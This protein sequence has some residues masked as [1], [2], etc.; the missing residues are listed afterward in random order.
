MAV[1]T[2]AVINAKEKRQQ[3]RLRKKGGK[4][5]TP[6]LHYPKTLNVKNA[7]KAAEIIV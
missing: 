2:E 1:R 7:C 5:C 6:F 3:K 4:I